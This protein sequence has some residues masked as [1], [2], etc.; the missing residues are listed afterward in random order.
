MGEVEEHRVRLVLETEPVGANVPARGCHAVPQTVRLELLPKRKLISCH[1][2]K[3]H[4][5]MSHKCNALD[6]NS[7]CIVVGHNFFPG[8]VCPHLVEV[9]GVEVAA[10]GDGARDG[11]A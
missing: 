2:R 7:F 9:E 10:G 5:E 1:P 3:I 6:D 8:G 4:N 11:V